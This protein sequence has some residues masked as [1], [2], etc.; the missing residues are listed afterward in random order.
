[1]KILG[2]Q[3]WASHEPA[4]AI[5][6]DDGDGSE[7]VSAL[8]TEERLLRCKNS[9]QFP[10]HALVDCM[11]RLGIELLREIDYLATDYSKLPRWIDSGPHYRKLLH[12]YIKLK[13]DLP[14]DRIV[15]VRHHDAHAATAFYPAGYDEA[16][17]LVVDGVGSENETTSLYRGEGTRI[18]CVERATEYGV[19]ALYDLVTVLLGLVGNHRCAQPGKTMGLAPY[20]A[21][22]PGPV[23]DLA[24]RGDGLAIDY[25]HFMSRLP[26][27][28]LKQ[29]LAPCPSK[30][31]VT[32]PHY[33]RIAYDVQAEVERA[34]VHLARYALERTG[35]SNLVFAGGTGLNCVANGI[36]VKKV[37]VD[38]F[39]VY[40]ACSDEGIGLGAALYAYYNVLPVSKSKRFV[41]PHAYTGRTFEQKGIRELLERLEVPFD[42]CTPAHVAERLASGEIVGWF[43]GGSESGP[44]ALGHRSILADPRD[45]TMKDV[46]NNRVKHRE[47]YRPFAPSVLEAQAAEFFHLD[48]PS[49]YM[50]LAGPVR[51]EKQALIPAVVHVDGTSRI[52]T[53]S[54]TDGGVYFEVIEAFR[55]LT[56]I[57]M[58]LNTSFNDNNEPMVETP[59][60]AMI[61]FLS[62]E[63]DALYLEGVIVDKARVPAA[64]AAPL[65]ARLREERQERQQTRFNAFVARC[66]CSWSTADIPGYHT[67]ALVRA[68][69]HRQ[70]EALEALEHFVETALADGRRVGLV[71]TRDHTRLLADTIRG[72]RDLD[73]VYVHH[74]AECDWEDMAS[75]G[76]E[77][78]EGSTGAPEVILITTY[79]WQREAARVA[80]ALFDPAVEIVQVYRSWSENPRFVF[81]DGR[82]HADQVPD[83]PGEQIFFGDLAAMW[84]VEQPD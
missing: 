61:T 24:P 49:P 26:F 66:C 83:D 68:L 44:R 69:W 54:R 9:Y 63:L 56:G 25:S 35:S 39:Y 50:L 2:L 21:M 15:V 37:S 67:R 73:I 46:I 4:A 51:E 72:F 58:V 55:R 52:Q 41:M 38:G 6:S 10:A 5:L 42:A 60:D 70:F 16:A 47:A 20:G 71:G 40:P 64:V 28:R 19:G 43:T 57:P 18:E 53:V 75:M 78:R 81:D 59:E 32:S 48:R 29:A 74:L 79:E 36:I 34:L 8:A 45:P 27:Y 23:L 77:P 12:D 80:A 31:E 65:A 33:A 76:V 62:T 7:L 84:P 11:D 82:P 3:S 30:T 17:I 13:L 1:M 22:A 14:E